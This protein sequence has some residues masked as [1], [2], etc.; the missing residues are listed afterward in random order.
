MWSTT[1][2]GRFIS[3]QLRHGDGADKLDR[4]AAPPLRGIASLCRLNRSSGLVSNNCA[5]AA[6]CNYNYRRID[7]QLRD[8]GAKIR[9][10][11]A[12][13]AEF[14]YS[15]SIK[16]TWKGWLRKRIERGYFCVDTIDTKANFSTYPV[17][18][19]PNFRIRPPPL[20]LCDGGR[21]SLQK[22]NPVQPV[23]LGSAEGNAEWPGE[24]L[25][26]P[27]FF[28][29]ENLKMDAARVEN[30]STPICWRIL[31]FSSH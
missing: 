14:K 20:F 27:I 21:F 19:A 13:L 5:A 16:S 7:E 8:Y 28:Y 23:I 25:L 2:T 15:T 6:T 12:S 24:S 3:V 4:V 22:A 31:Q 10:G 30:V 17:A 11:G 26:V 1:P 9:R 29:K 18:K